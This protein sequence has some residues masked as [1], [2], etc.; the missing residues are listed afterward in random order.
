MN[1]DDGKC[2]EDFLELYFSN[3]KR[4]GGGSIQEVRL[5]GRGEAIIT[6]EKPEGWFSHCMRSYRCS[7]AYD[8]DLF[9][10]ISML[11]IVC[12]QVNIVCRTYIIRIL[13]WFEQFLHCKNSMA[14]GITINCY[15][16]PLQ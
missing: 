7:N 9:S 10:I 1:M 11:S 5:I 15:E 4:S 12:K 16:S 6:F 8:V 3:E 2:D 13:W 14:T